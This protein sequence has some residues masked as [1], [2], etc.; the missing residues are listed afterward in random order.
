MP[1]SWHWMLSG[2]HPHK[3]KRPVLTRDGSFRIVLF[4]P[5]Q[6][7]QSLAESPAPERPMPDKGDPR[8]TDLDDAVIPITETSWET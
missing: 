8:A 5:F 1:D 4:A 2:P 6:N 7:M 3:T